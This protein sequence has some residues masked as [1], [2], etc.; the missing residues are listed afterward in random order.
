MSG[1]LPSAA[2]RRD[3][4][5]RLRFAKRFSPPSA[6]LTT[7]YLARAHPHP[8]MLSVLCTVQT[9]A[10]A[11][12][13]QLPELLARLGIHQLHFASVS[14]KNSEL[15]LDF[16]SPFAQEQVRQTMANCEFFQV[17]PTLT[18]SLPGIPVLPMPQCMRPWTTMYVNVS[19]QIGYCDHLIGPFAESQLLGHLSEGALAVWNNERWQ[20]I[21]TRHVLRSPQFKKCVRCYRDKGVDF[22]P[23]WLGRAWV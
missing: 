6:P 20:K 19:G 16:D 14:S 2:R 17:I 3:V 13:P 7:R 22:E 21:R 8:E 18:T 4:S 1:E 12:L 9:P 11:S 23:M 5:L 10:L 15:A